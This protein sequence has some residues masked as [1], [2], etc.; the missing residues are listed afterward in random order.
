MPVYCKGGRKINLDLI[1]LS[2]FGTRGVPLK[3]NPT[4]PKNTSV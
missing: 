2:H 3:K 1:T 4:K